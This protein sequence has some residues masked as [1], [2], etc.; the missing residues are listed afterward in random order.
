LKKIIQSYKKILDA[1]VIDCQA[2]N[3]KEVYIDA[4]RNVFPCC[5]LASAP[6]TFIEQGNEAT[7]IKT[8][9]LNQYHDLV[10]SLG[11]LDKL[12]A[13]D[14][15]L[16]EIVDSKEY[17]TVWEEYWTTKKLITCARTCGRAEISDFAKSRDQQRDVI[18]L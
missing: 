12:N 5:W 4:Y 15:T 13:I 17:Q 16:E 14:Y 10:H 9:M 8:E 18:K 1:S 7:S 3:Q 6:Y 11:G 2:Y